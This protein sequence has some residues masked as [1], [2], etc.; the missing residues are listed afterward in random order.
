M[1]IFYFS[2]KKKKKIYNIKKNENKIKDFY[3]LIFKF[4]TI[5]KSSY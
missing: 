1:K 5:A 2:K 3:Q 4:F